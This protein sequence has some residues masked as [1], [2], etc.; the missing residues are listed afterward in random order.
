RRC[1]PVVLLCLSL[2]LPGCSKSPPP[3]TEAEGVVLLN[4]KPLPNALV[5]FV[6]Q[7]SNFGAE[8]N[9]TAVT[10]DEG[11][12]KLEMTYRSQPGAVVGKHKVMVTEA[13]PS[14]E[15]RGMSEK[16]QAG[17]ADQLAK[18]KN[19]P[20]PTRYGA[21]GTTPVEVEVKPGES[22]KIELTRDAKDQGK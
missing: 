14:G 12:F 15:F 16:A 1:L 9:S 17:Y 8:M 11:R 19:R 18:L 13:P 10:D 22:L 2:A 6:P 4:G 21:V 3:V 20:I 7:L 5:T